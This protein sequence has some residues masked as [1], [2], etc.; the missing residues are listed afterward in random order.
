MANPTSKLEDLPMD[1][2]NIYP[3]FPTCLRNKH[4][5]LHALFLMQRPDS[6]CNLVEFCI[7]LIIVI[8]YALELEAF[9]TPIHCG[10]R[11]E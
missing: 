10:E 4:I 5:H 1:E 6:Y 9:S 3:L 2:Y 7:A 8:K 11:D